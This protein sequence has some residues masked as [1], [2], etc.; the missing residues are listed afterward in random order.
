MEAEIEKRKAL[1]MAAIRQAFG[2]DAGEE[3][4]NLFVE[5]HL[6]E[7]G[8]D[9][10]K[11]HLGT[12]TPEPAAVLGLLQFDSSWGEGDVEYF[13]FTLPDEVTNYVVSVHFDSAGDIDEISMES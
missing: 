8:Q 11:Q 2:S 10:W 12:G 3:N 4:I 7:L 13:D 9:Y 6:E 1:A 5:H